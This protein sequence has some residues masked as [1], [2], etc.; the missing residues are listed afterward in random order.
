MPPIHY[1]AGSPEAVAEIV[2]LVEKTRAAQ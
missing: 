2:A 1:T